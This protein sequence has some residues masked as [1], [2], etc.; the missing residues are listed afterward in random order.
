M[1]FS[2]GE[3]DISVS[4]SSYPQSSAFDETRLANIRNQVSFLESRLKQAKI[5]QDP[6][7][8]DMYEKLLRSQNALLKSPKN[9]VE[10]NV[11]VL[12]V[13]KQVWV[14]DFFEHESVKKQVWEGRIEHRDGR[15]WSISFDTYVKPDGTPLFDSRFS[16]RVNQIFFSKKSAEVALKKYHAK[17]QSSKPKYT[18][19]EEEDSEEEDDNEDEV[20]ENEEEDDNEDEEDDNEDEED[21]NEDEGEG[22]EDEGED[23]EDKGEDNEDEG[24][25]NK[26][27]GEDNEDKG[28]DNKDEGEDNEAHQGQEEE[29]EEEQEE[30]K[31]EGEAPQLQGHLKRG[32]LNIGDRVYFL[33]NTQEE[34]T[35][36]SQGKVI[37][38]V[39]RSWKVE[40]LVD[41]KKIVVQRQAGMLFRDLSMAKRKL[42]EVLNFGGRRKKRRF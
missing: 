18:T 36:I 8:I 37:A 35:Q 25:D 39:S 26:G 21:D 31:P 15:R 40:A 38:R 34:E 32:G 22:N 9:S 6:A 4:S 28:E 2:L 20:E 1:I 42:D 23:N 12:C 33:M 19:S 13:G 10:P 7:A 16:Y 29:H 3:L 14:L 11:Q 30:E 17:L 24:E 41:N 5:D 27:K